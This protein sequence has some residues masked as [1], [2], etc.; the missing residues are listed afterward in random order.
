MWLDNKVELANLITDN[1]HN[2]IIK[3]LFAGPN[4]ILFF[5]QIRFDEKIRLSQ[6]FLTFTKRLV[7]SCYKIG[8][9]KFKLSEFLLKNLWLFILN[10][11]NCI[12]KQIIKL[13]NY[14]WFHRL[15]S[16]N[17]CLSFTDLLIICS[18]KWCPLKLT[19]MLSFIICLI[20]NRSS[21]DLARSC[22]IRV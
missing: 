15:N 6:S 18:F 9:R 10:W 4:Q 17:L 13:K 20:R 7:W 1:L 22:I 2:W 5:F 19:I 16:F 21:I 8:Y 14:Y 12:F 3:W 11:F